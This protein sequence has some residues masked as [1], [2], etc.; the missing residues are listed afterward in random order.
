VSCVLFF[1]GNVV[2]GGGV[3]RSRPSMKVAKPFSSDIICV[4]RCVVYDTFD[5]KKCVVCGIID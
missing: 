1:S 2:G 5:W 4:R 3:K